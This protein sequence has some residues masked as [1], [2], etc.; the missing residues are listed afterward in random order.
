MRCQLRH[1]GIEPTEP[2]RVALRTPPRGRRA[3]PT[4]SGPLALS[5]PP[6]TTHALAVTADALLQVLPADECRRL[7]ASAHIGRVVFTNAALPTA[8]P[9][10][11]AMVGADII[12]RSGPGLKLS[13][14]LAGTVVAF[15]VD[16]FND[17]LRVGWSVVVTSFASVVVDPAEVAQLDRL[18][19]PIWISAA[20]AQYIRLTTD[21]QITGRRLVPPHEAS[22]ECIPDRCPC[23]DRSCTLSRYVRATRAAGTTTA[24]DDNPA[25]LEAA[26]QAVAERLHGLDIDMDAMAAVQNVNRAANAIRKRC[27]RTVLT[28]HGLT[29]TAWI[30]LWAGWIWG[31]IETRHLAYEAGIS[32]PTLTWVLS[33]LEARGLLQRRPYPDDARR[34]LVSLTAEGQALMADLLPQINAQERLI[35][36]SLSDLQTTAL[37]RQ[38]RTV[39]ARVEALQDAKPPADA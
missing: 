26:D 34:V 6:R 24:S 38:L 25:S 12:F 36:D 13:A 21:G 33:S 8:L 35:T 37:A 29:W 22:T 14:A 32:K 3:H 19:I 30:V 17:D 2:S 11:Y 16:D 1:A 23:D 4:Q 31:D 28:P 20:D 5:R 39:V 10:N 15:E 18:G 27:E 7:L 9:V